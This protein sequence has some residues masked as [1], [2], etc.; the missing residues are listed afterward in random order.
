M[1]NT[2]RTTQ[3]IR[4]IV[5]VRM[6]TSSHSPYAPADSPSQV[7]EVTMYCMLCGLCVVYVVTIPDMDSMLRQQ[8][9]PVDEMEWTKV[10]NSP[11]QQKGEGMQALPKG[12]IMNQMCVPWLPVKLPW[13][14]LHQGTG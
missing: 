1:W 8:A 11:E 9:L 10:N 3:S 2:F 5:D 6:F 7:S 13:K 14:N 4:I 12:P